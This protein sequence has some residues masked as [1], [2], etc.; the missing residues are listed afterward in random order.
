MPHGSWLS[1]LATGLA[2]LL[3]GL[4]PRVVGTLYKAGRGQEGMGLGDADLMMMVGCFLGWQPVVVAFIIAL[5]PGLLF[6]VLQLISRGD[7]PFPFGPSLAIG[8][9]IAWLGWG[10]FAPRLAEWLFNGPLLL[11]VGIGGAIFLFLASVMLRAIRGP[12]L[13]ETDG[14]PPAPESGPVPPME[15]ASSAPQAEPP[16]PVAPPSSETP[17]SP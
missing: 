2:G 14:E 11:G 13:P 15:D 8:T 17:S 9:I 1:G 7:R 4:L 3:A 5:A 10:W 12:A 6:G 16:A